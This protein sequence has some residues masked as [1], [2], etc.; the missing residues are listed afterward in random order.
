LLLLLLVYKPHQLYIYI[1]WYT[2][3]WYR[4]TGHK[5]PQT[6]RKREASELWDTTLWQWKTPMAYGTP[7]S[8]MLSKT[9]RNLGY[10]YRLLHG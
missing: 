8:A 4:Y 5:Q 2:I 1:E 9:W 10:N 7:M 6:K 3:E